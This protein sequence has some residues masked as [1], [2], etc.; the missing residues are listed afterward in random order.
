MM[1]QAGDDVSDRIK[2]L[3]D[4]IYAIVGIGSLVPELTSSPS[5]EEPRAMSLML[6]VL[7]FYPQLLGLGENLRSAAGAGSGE[8]ARTF[9]K[10][11]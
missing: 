1:Q 7:R 3:Y 2:L 5:N 9:I 8:Q 11:L 10:T 6:R 4:P